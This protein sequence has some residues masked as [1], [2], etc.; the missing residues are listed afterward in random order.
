MINYNLNIWKILVWNLPMKAALALSFWKGGIAALFWYS[1]CLKSFHLNYSVS[2]A[3]RMEGLH[4]LLGEGNLE[5]GQH[6]SLALSLSCSSCPPCNMPGR[7]HQQSA[8]IPFS[9]CHW[10]RS[11]RRGGGNSVLSLGT[12]Y[13]TAIYCNKFIAIFYWM[14]FQTFYEYW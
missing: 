6:G 3:R 10:K 14:T 7:P 13:C 12:I 5:I 9:S 11:P 4:N 2:L 1:L 8:P